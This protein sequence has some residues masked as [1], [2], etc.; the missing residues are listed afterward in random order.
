MMA[1]FGMV[2]LLKI[3]KHLR[4]CSHCR[5]H[6]KT[7]HQCR[8]QTSRSLP[9]IISS[10][11]D[12]SGAS[13]TLPEDKLRKGHLTLDLVDH[14]SLQKDVL[15]NEIN[16]EQMLSDIDPYLSKGKMCPA[17]FLEKKN[18]GGEEKCP[19][20]PIKG[21]LEIYP[22]KEFVELQETS[23]AKEL[24]H[25]SLQQKRKSFETLSN[26]NNINFYP[27][28]EFETSTFPKYSSIK[29]KELHNSNMH[30]HSCIR[31]SSAHSHSD[32]YDLR[33]SMS[34]KEDSTSSFKTNSLKKQN[35]KYL[36]N[37][38]SFVYKD[39][40]KNS[41]SLACSFH[42][43]KNVPTTTK[44]STK[45]KPLILNPQSLGV[46]TRKM[47]LI[48]P[49][50][51]KSCFTDQVQTNLPPPPAFNQGAAEY[52]TN[53][54]SCQKP[55]PIEIKLSNKVSFDQEYLGL[56]MQTYNPDIKYENG[57]WYIPSL[58][59]KS[60]YLGAEYSYYNQNTV[61]GLDRRCCSSI[62]RRYPLHRKN[63]A[64]KTS[65]IRNRRS[66]SMSYDWNK[67]TSCDKSALLTKTS[68]YSFD[69]PSHL[70]LQPYCAV[71]G[72]K[73]GMCKN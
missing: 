49:D 53:E 41:F 4:H 27:D 14:R 28:K 56:F 25:L 8:A 23:K 38:D 29:A 32:L 48:S 54:D 17:Q 6:I 30:L 12:A 58:S 73:K 69:N 62:N 31:M 52:Q 3:R 40:L 59:H 60:T 42:M 39:Q 44:N 26:I 51:I 61:P 33:E 57:F 19:I 18:L 67:S 43:E 22:E 70:I 68:S 10:S 7:C 13:Q 9:S 64:S 24:S 16:K 21:P 65:C 5:S 11:K 2:W 47:P 71:H 72:Y 20:L 34:F 36:K 15:L 63:S 45:F 66:A 37:E 1:L 55:L 46:N 35:Y 50:N